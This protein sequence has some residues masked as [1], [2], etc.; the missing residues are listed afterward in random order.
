MSL[1]LVRE[2]QLTLKS[3]RPSSYFRFTAN[4]INPRPKLRKPRLS[5]PKL[6]AQRMRGDLHTRVS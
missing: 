1:A 5:R 4:K 2:P 6:D 3:A